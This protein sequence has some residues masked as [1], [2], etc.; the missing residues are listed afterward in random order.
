[1]TLTMTEYMPF[2][3][4]QAMGLNLALNEHKHRRACSEVLRFSGKSQQ[5]FG[6]VVGQ[7]PD[8]F[9]KDP[10]FLFV[11]FIKPTKVIQRKPD[12]EQIHWKNPQTR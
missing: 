1:M 5:H 4:L 6:M 10:P 3:K 11:Q 12:F 2:V 8:T 9:A 7:T